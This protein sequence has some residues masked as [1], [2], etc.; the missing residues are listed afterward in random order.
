MENNYYY[1]VKIR[2]A[3]KNNLPETIIARLI[4]IEENVFQF[5]LNNDHYVF[6]RGKYID[7]VMPYYS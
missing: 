6:L 2:N 4:G 1:T 5:K 7:Y 3:K